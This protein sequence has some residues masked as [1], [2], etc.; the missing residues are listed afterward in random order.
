MMFSCLLNDVIGCFELINS[1][2]MMLMMYDYGFAGWGFP[3]GRCRAC[4]VNGKVDV[5]LLSISQ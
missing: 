4:E 5:S 2:G 3:F 1:G